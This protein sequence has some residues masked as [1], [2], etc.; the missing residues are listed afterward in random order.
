VFALRPGKGVSV[1][2]AR[3]FAAPVSAEV[4]S[5]ASIRMAATGNIESVCQTNQNREVCI[6]VR[7]LAGIIQILQQLFQLLVPVIDGV[8]QRR[9]Y[10][11]HGSGNAEAE[12]I[13]KSR[14]QRGGQADRYAGRLSGNVSAVAVLGPHR[15]GIFTVILFPAVGTAESMA[16]V[17]VVIDTETEL[18]PVRSFT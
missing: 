15:L 3:I 6:P 8:M 7:N 14:L 9:N 5:A 13:K 18:S 12:F 16:A 4:A 11:R 10:I 17:E 1:N 2:Q